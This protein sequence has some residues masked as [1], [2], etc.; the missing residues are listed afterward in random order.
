MSGVIEFRHY[1]YGS[2]HAVAGVGAIRH[3][4]VEVKESHTSNNSLSF[5]TFNLS[6]CSYNLPFHLLMW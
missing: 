2:Q 4:T 3:G 1:N 6:L 5:S